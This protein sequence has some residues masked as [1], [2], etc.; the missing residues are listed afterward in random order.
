M[1]KYFQRI[2]QGTG[3]QSLDEA[4]ASGQEN[5]SSWIQ[6][7]EGFFESN[8]FQMFCTNPCMVNKDTFHRM[9]PKQ[10]KR[11]VCSRF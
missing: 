4:Y 11:Y 6:N 7:V 9:F 5:D 3:N 2:T 10:V 8:G 1:L